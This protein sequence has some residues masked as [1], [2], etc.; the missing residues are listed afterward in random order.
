M[1]LATDLEK[2]RIVMFIQ[3]LLS[4]VEFSF[5][6]V[7]QYPLAVAWATEGLRKLHRHYE[8][9]GSLGGFLGSG[10]P[11]E[12]LRLRLTKDQDESQPLPT[13]AWATS[14]WLFAVVFFLVCVCTR[15]R[16]HMYECAG[17]QCWL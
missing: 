12:L 10:S 1:D 3:A 4:K 5:I 8:I 7:S 6:T 17:D 9:R 11:V 15:V 16:T 2:Q 14:A 13:S